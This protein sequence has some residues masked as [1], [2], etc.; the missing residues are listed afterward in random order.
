MPDKRPI[1][2]SI[3]TVT[4]QAGATIERTLQSVAQQ[5]Y[6]HVEYII[7]DGAS[8]DTTL[9]IIQQY[10]SHVTTLVSEPDKGLYDAMNKAM[11]GCTGDYVIFL[12]AGDKLHDAETLNKVAQILG[13]DRPNVLYGDTHIV[14][15]EGKFLYLRELRPPEVLTWKSFRWGMLVCHQSFWVHRALLRPYDTQYR[16]SADFDWCIRILKDSRGVRNMQLPLVDYLQEGMT[17]QNHRA[18]LRERYHIMCRYYG[19]LPTL[20]MHVIFLLRQA[21]RKVRKSFS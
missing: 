7:M 9:S 4:Y 11:D 16:F 19:T 17:T 13:N 1:A 8:T 21:V 12:N 14:D 15:D 10:A 5:T 6:P 3:I 20:F 18:S 2:F